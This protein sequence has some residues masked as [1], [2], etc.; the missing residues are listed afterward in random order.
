MDSLMRYA[1]PG[2][3]RELKSALQYAFTLAEKGPLDISHLPPQM[4]AADAPAVDVAVPG[5]HRERRERQELI[6]AL[7]ATGGNQT[8]AAQL[9]GINRVTVWNRMRKYGLDLKRELTANPAGPA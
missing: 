3:V 4:F 7:Q 1:F 5:N 8:R 2:N 6:D 9:L